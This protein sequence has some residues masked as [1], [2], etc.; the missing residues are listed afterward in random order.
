MASGRID[1]SLVLALVLLR[2][3]VTYQSDRIIF[4]PIDSGRNAFKHLRLLL[5]DLFCMSGCNYLYAD[6]MTVRQLALHRVR[7]LRTK[8]LGWAMP[9]WPF[10][11]NSAPDILLL[12]RAP[13]ASTSICDDFISAIN[14]YSGRYLN[15]HGNAGVSNRRATS[16]LQRSLAVT[17]RNG[18]KGPEPVFA[19]LRSRVVLKVRFPSSRI[20]MM[21]T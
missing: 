2:L 13:A 8:A 14:T 4:E 12:D 1:F 20:E 19:S 15:L 6:T 21:H 10:E 7:L 9:A 16:S 18:R 11:R 5:S 17:Q 3:F